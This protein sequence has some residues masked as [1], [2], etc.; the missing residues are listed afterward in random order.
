MAWEEV[1][2][3]CTK[4]LQQNIWPSNENYGTNCDNL[5]MLIKIKEISETAEVVGLDNVDSV[6]ITE[7]LESHSQPLSNEELYGLTQELTEQQQEDEDEEDCGTKELQTKD[8]AGILSA[9]DVATEK[10]CDIDSDWERSSTVKR[11]IRAMLHPS[12]EIL[13]GKKKKSKQL[14]LPS[15]LMSS[16]PQPGPPSAK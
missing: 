8:F 15:F 10:L 3:L 11:G 16:E 14:T 13:Q 2:A 1:T 4:G 12:Y 7:V 6:G 5:D 9:I